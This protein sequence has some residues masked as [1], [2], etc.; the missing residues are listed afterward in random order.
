MESTVRPGMAKAHTIKSPLCTSIAC[1]LMMPINEAAK[2]I[3]M[4]T[5][6]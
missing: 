5:E 3:G 4:E 1:D 2:G 6:H